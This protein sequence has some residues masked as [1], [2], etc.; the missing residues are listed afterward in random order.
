[1]L[2]SDLE[3]TCWQVELKYVTCPSGDAENEKDFKANNRMREKINI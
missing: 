2:D 1:M 3:V